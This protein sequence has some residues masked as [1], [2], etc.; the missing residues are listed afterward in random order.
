MDQLKLRPIFVNDE[1][2][3]PVAVQVDLESFQHVLELLSALLRDGRVPAGV[4]ADDPVLR[5][6]SAMLAEDGEEGDP[7][8][9]LEE[10]LDTLTLLRAK[11]AAEEYVD[12][13]DIRAELLESDRP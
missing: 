5:Q 6:L 12:Y 13:E 3:R 8:E 1:A 11:A 7:R 4:P 2:G 10:L 9:R